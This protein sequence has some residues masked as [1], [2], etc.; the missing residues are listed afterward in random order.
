MRTGKILHLLAV[1][2]LL[3]ACAR[4]QNRSGTSIAPTSKSAGQTGPMEGTLKVNG[5]AR[6]YRLYVPTGYSGDQDV[7]LILNFHGF[8]ANSLDE[9]ELSGMS[10]KA[11]KAGFIVAYPD[12][13][14]RA[15]NDGTGPRQ[16]DDVAFAR[17]LIQSLATRYHI[18]P[19]RV[20]ATGISNGGGMTNRLACELADQIAAIG[21]VAGAYNLWQDCAPSRP[22]PV[23]AF[24]GTADQIVPF[25]GSRPESIL[26]P[27]A[28]WAK[29]WAERNHCNP[30]EKET[31]L[32]PDVH[33]STWGNCKNDAE[34]I[35]YVIDNHGHSWP[36]SSFLK[37][38]TSQSVNA[39]DVMWDFFEKH[40]MP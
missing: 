34:V 38:I 3:A 20:Y 32:H 1:L 17:E 39:T 18:D 16:Q 23:I 40:P 7:A 33:V 30:L 22:I 21:P 27:I 5:A 12:G 14:N 35:L 4:F 36:G 31:D 13:L 28:A 19:R 11:E 26:P 8:G 6:H 37:E 29:A 24:H 9:E 25:A 10:L 2:F 15:W